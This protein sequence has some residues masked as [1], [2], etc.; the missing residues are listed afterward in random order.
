[1]DDVIVAFLQSFGR[2][3]DFHPSDKR[4]KGLHLTAFVLTSSAV[5]K[6]SLLAYCSSF[7]P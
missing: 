4:W 7:P 2:F 3:G 5:L 1:M 6:N